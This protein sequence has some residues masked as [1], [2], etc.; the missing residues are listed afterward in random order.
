MTVIT[1]L[2]D[3]GG[4][5][6]VDIFVR[7]DETYGFKEFRRDPEDGGRWSLV[8]DYSSLVFRTKDEALHGAAA[9]IGWFS[10][11]KSD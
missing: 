10:L 5:R 11:P 3:P 7:E 9:A 1:S 8:R 4:L 6:C 2:E